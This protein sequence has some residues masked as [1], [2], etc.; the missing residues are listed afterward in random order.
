M[1]IMKKTL[2]EKVKRLSLDM[3]DEWIYYLNKKLD[4]WKMKIP[5]DGKSRTYD[6]HGPYLAL[7]TDLHKRDPNYLYFIDE[8]GDISRIN[9]LEVE[10]SH[11]LER[12]RRFFSTKERTDKNE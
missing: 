8:D 3:K 2:T 5:E 7:E 6:E 1:L 12:M 4:V 9:M 10:R 11:K